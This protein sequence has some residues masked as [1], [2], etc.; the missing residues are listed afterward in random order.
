MRRYC[1][2]LMVMLVFYPLSGEARPGPNG[3]MVLGPG[4]MSCAHWTKVRRDEVLSTPVVTWVMGF[5][6]SYNRYGPGSPD[7]TQGRN[8]DGIPGWI[9][10]YCAQ[11]PLNNIADAAENL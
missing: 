4:G 8:A 10:N 6:A 11:N 5:V 7:I 9:D 1:W 3:Y 2:W